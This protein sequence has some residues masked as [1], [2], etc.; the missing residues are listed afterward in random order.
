M[1]SKRRMRALAATLVAVFVLG[2]VVGACGK[3]GALE[4]PPGKQSEFP[5]KYPR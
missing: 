4:P 5:R 3:K 2:I 1:T